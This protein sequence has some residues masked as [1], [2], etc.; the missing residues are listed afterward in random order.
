MKKLF[1]KW[2]SI[3]QSYSILAPVLEAMT[4]ELQKEISRVI[5]EGLMSQSFVDWE[6]SDFRDHVHGEE[7]CKTKE[8]IMEDIKT[9]FHL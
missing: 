1:D 5:Y 9:V 4:A 6:E 8:E 7:N 3:K 2:T